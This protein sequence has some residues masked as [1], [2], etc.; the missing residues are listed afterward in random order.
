LINSG[1]EINIIREEFIITIR[2]LIVSLPRELRNQSI[3]NI[4]G[5]IEGFIGIILKALVILGGIVIYIPLLI[6]KYII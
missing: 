4:H 5:G 6:V 1:A 3:K 2:L